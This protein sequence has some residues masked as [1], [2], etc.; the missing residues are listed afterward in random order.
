MVQVFVPEGEFER[1]SAAGDA[2]GYDDERPA[3]RVWVDSFWID[4]TEVT[5]AMFGAFVRATGF[6]T[7]AEREGEGLVFSLETG[8]WE[9]LPGADWT[10]PRGPGEAAEVLGE[11]PVGQMAWSD[12]AAYC[13]WAGRRL[14]TEA[15]WEKAARGTDGR[16]YPWGDEPPDE[17][18]VNL[19]DLHLPVVDWADAAVDDGYA[20]SAPAGSYPAGASP[21]GALDMAGNIWEWVADWFAADYYAA[22]PDRNPAGPATGAEH[23]LRGGSWWSEA[24]GVRAAV[25]DSAADFAYD[26]YGFRCAG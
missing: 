12:A 9:A 11:H 14:P 10:R 5:Q 21:Y 16:R 25:R 20:F 23:A 8:E 3:H 26:N 18:R 4:R 1:G 13:E 17:S 24:R 6:E 2:L 15:E 7:Y 22:S 19:A